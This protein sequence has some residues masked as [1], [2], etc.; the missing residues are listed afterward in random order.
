[1]MSIGLQNE[2]GVRKPCHI[3]LTIDM[4]KHQQ[5]VAIENMR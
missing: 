5:K 3:E 2:D 4:S 1:M